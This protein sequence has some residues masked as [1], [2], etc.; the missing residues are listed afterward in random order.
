[1]K[2]EE[3]KQAVKRL[4]D[5]ADETD[6]GIDNEGVHIDEDEL[7]QDVLK[8]IASGN[9]DDPTELAREALKTLDLNY[10]RWYA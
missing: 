6:G 5:E 4:Y 2:L 7:H 8:A 1:M 9:C 3:V 10:A